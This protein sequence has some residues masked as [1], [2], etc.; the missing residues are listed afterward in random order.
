M[1]KLKAPAFGKSVSFNQHSQNVTQQVAYVNRRVVSAQAAI[2]QLRALLTKA[3]SVSQLLSV[4]NTINNQE[5]DLEALL[6]QQRALAHE[7]SYATV[8]VLLVG[9]H[10]RIV[11]KH[12]KKAATGFLGGL[13]G[14]WPAL[15]LVVG[16][17]LTPLGPAWP[18]PI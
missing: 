17:P 13:R 4:Q 7:T 10:A 12:Q 8:T 16:G 14:G 9:H 6:A 11:K 18:C 2:K 5:S 1:A 15:G 3:G